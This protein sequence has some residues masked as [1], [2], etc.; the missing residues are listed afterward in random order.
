MGCEN[1]G[2]L[3]EG[4]YCDCMIVNGEFKGA[5]WRKEDDNMTQKATRAHVLADETIGGIK[6]EYVE[7]ERKAVV[8]DYA[9]IV[10][11]TCNGNSEGFIG[12]I[13]EVDPFGAIFEG[14]RANWHDN[15]RVLEPTDNVII[16]ND[17]SPGSRYKL[18]DRKADVGERVIIVNETYPGSSKTSYKNGDIF[19]ASRVDYDDILSLKGTDARLY[20]TEYRVLEPAADETSPQSTDDII[21][22]LARRVAGLERSQDGLKRDVETWAQEIESLKYANKPQQITLDVEVLARLLGGDC[23]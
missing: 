1:C 9:I 4:G 17:N 14:G 19:T 12:K 18:V 11:N 16:G 10:R 20:H 22:N 7:V 2:R 23:R 6:R 8:G 5:H 3:T 15:Y 13:T 21:A